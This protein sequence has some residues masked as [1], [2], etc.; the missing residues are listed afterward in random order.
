MTNNG[1][2]IANLTCVFLGALGVCDTLYVES[3]SLPRPYKSCDAMS[4][5]GR[6]MGGDQNKWWVRLYGWVQVCVIVVYCRF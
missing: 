2:K 3:P 6:A 1:I 5:D 4:G